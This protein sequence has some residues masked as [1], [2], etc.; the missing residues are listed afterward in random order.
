MDRKKILIACLKWTLGLVGVFALFH[1]KAGGVLWEKVGVAK[2]L[3]TYAHAIESVQDKVDDLREAH[4]DNERLRVENANLRARLDQAGFDCSAKL[5]AKST[6]ELAAVERDERLEQKLNRAI[7]SIHYRAPD[8][9]LPEQLIS[10]GMGYFRAKEDDKAAV[11]FTQL[12]TMED[13]DTYKTPKHLL[14]TGIAWYRTE[15]L[16]VADLFFEKVLKTKG[17]KTANPIFAQARLWRGLVAERLGQHTK[18]QSWLVDLVD[19]HP[20]STEAEWVNGGRAIED[21]GHM[22]S[23]GHAPA[24]VEHAKSEAK[25]DSHGAE[26]KEGHSETPKNEHHQDEGDHGAHH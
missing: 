13:V 7:T 21:A 18:S 16:E 9:L 17:E 2:I 15:N 1:P 12:A 8:H 23:G 19:H 14:M 4:Q 6:G 5:S 25:V 20:M 24:S 10:L 11:I 26:H 22:K 3:K